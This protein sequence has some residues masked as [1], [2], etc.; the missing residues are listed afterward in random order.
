REHRVRA[1][2]ER[3][4]GAAVRGGGLE[5]LHQ[6]PFRAAT[7]PGHPGDAPRTGPRAV[8][9]EAGAVTSALPEAPPAPARLA[10]PLSEKMD[11]P[12]AP[13]QPAPRPPPRRL[14]PSRTLPSQLPHDDRRFI[15][16][17]QAAPVP[18][19]TNPRTPSCAPPWSES[20]RDPDPH[21][22]GAVVGALQVIAVVAE[23]VQDRAVERGIPADRLADPA[24]D[25]DAPGG[26]ARG[27]EGRQDELVVEVLVLHLAEELR[28]REVLHEGARAVVV[29]GDVLGIAAVV[30][31]A[32]QETRTDR[33]LGV[34]P[35]AD[36]RLDRDEVDVAESETDPA[37]DEHPVV[38]GRLR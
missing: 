34:D 28:H 26:I 29:G 9:L 38:P 17:S 4:H 20:R 1:A 25:V 5:E 6:G 19:A 24:A 36:E 14:I 32:V 15:P 10:R 16:T 23:V 22:P 18:R 30:G 33:D 13:E 7:R 35:P 37:A 27:V 31:E 11:D 12:G 21:H 2:A 3:G 8:D